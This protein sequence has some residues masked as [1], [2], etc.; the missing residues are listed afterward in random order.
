MK[1]RKPKDYWVNTD[2]IKDEIKTIIQQIGHFPTTTELKNIGRQDLIGGI[3]KHTNGIPHIRTN[4]GFNPLKKPKN[5]W[6]VDTIKKEMDIAIRENGKFPTKSD[7]AKLGRGDLAGAIQTYTKGIIWLRQEM[8][9]ELTKGSTG[10]WKKFSN[11]EKELLAI[12]QKIGK[13]PDNKILR[14]LHESSLSAAI[15]IYHH[16]QHIKFYLNKWLIM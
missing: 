1:R 5:Y 13:F 4:M 10:Y 16:T 9:Y 7:L 6:N 14:E 15:T 12:I 8:G 11:V 3:R 2:H